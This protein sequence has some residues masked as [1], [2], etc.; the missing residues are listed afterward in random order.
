MEAIYR[1]GKPNKIREAGVKGFCLGPS[2]PVCSEK[3]KKIR[4]F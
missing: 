4:S 3:Q 2:F 1:A